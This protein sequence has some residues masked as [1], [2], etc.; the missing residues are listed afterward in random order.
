MLTTRSDQASNKPSGK[1]WAKLIV[2][3]LV[4]IAAMDAFLFFLAGRWDWWAVWIFSF[5]YLLFLL[6]F[7]AWIP[8]DLVEE[9]KKVAPNVKPWDK[10]I[11]GIYS[12]LVF[13]LV[14][15]A[16][17]DAGRFGWSEMPVIWQVI[18]L[19]V[20]VPCGAWILWTA[21]T[22]AYLSSYARIQEDRGQ[23]VITTGPYRYV[24]HPMY[25]AL[26]P[27]IVCMALIFGSWWALVPGAIVFA[28]FIVRTALE[29]RMLQA[30]LPGYKEYAQRVQY[31]LVPGV[32]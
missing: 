26:M 8:P 28:L 3:V 25:A 23:H 14:I 20:G 10:I 24:R 2:R 5:P 22:N 4:T 16:A 27:F 32:W 29:D 9:R 15:V 12:A 21:K 6:G 7:F 31:R 13:I 30:E 17:L 19:I 1:G 18:G 11:V